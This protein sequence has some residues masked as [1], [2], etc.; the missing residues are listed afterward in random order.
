MA[1]EAGKGCSG[2]MAENIKKR[3]AF[4]K[5]KIKEAGKALLTFFAVRG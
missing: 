2:N 4:V 3:K 5:E 1:S